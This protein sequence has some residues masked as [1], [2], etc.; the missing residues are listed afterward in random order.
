M[1]CAQSVTFMT[2]FVFQPCVILS[3][4]NLFRL[5]FAVKNILSFTVASLT[6]QAAETKKSANC[7]CRAERN[8][9]RLCWLPLLVG[10]SEALRASSL[11]GR[12]LTRRTRGTATRGCLTGTTR[13]TGDTL[14]RY[15]NSLRRRGDE[16]TGGG[17]AGQVLLWHNFTACFRALLPCFLTQS[18]QNHTW[19]QS[20]TLSAPWKVKTF[21]LFYFSSLFNLKIQKDKI[22]FFFFLNALFN[23]F[24]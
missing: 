3:L 4:A 6:H 19:F 17:K 16:R 1:L 23:F 14:P 13:G 8:N 12:D 7:W 15:S 2:Q 5:W 18:S 21:Y 20:L 10:R 11:T 9:S 22:F 24:L